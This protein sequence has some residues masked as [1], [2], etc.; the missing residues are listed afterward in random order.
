M[1]VHLLH[2]LAKTGEMQKIYHSNSPEDCGSSLRPI[3]SRLRAFFRE[4]PISSTRGTCVHPL[5]H[6]TKL[7]EM[8]NL[9]PS[10]VLQARGSGF[11]FGKLQILSICVHLMHPS[12]QIG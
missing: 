7:G 1:C 3:V 10:K 6:L 12:T 8:Q 4:A 11:F 9:H 5:H 2:H